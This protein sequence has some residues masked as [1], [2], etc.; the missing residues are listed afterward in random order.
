MKQAGFW[1]MALFLAATL[2]WPS[3]VLAAKDAAHGAASKSGT[4]AVETAPPGDS[5]Q[6]AP[7]G[8]EAPEGAPP[9]DA[10]G[11]MIKEPASFNGIKWGAKLADVPDLKVIGEYGGV[12]YAAVPDAVYR[13]GDVFVNEVTYAFCDEGFAAVRLE[14][15]GRDKLDSI[16]RIIGEKYST[17]VRLEGKT[18]QFG[19]PLGNVLIMLE[20][21][22]KTDAGAL[23]YSYRP[24][25]D[26]CIK[27]SK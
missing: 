2:S 18:E 10:P 19:L 1:A 7:V 15:T 17:P 4:Q 3:A 11:R 12:R 13:I 9:E 24:I 21:D 16:A 20:Y 6:A 8:G 22:P 25:F 23:G 27:K 5:G 14:F 26:N